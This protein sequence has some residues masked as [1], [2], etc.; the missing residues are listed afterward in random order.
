MMLMV[1]LFII[2]GVHDAK[3]FVQLCMRIEN[4][5][6]FSFSASLTITTDPI[7]VLAPIEDVTVE[8]DSK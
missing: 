3:L 1:R 8:D 7:T 6:V 2:P 4:I 5:S